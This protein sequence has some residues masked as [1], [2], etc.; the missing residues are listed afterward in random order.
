VSLT[1]PV[2]Q[3]SPVEAG[4]PAAAIIARLVALDHS[5]ATAESITGG[6]IAGRLTAVAGASAVFRGGLIVY[7][8]DLKTRLAG[9][10]ADLIAEAG[11]VSEATARGLAQGAQRAC[12]ADW[13][14][15]VT[16]VA[17]PGPSAGVPAGT[18][19][20]AVAGPGGSAAERLT[21]TGDR[22]AVRSA[23]VDAA[24]AALRSR[25]DTADGVFPGRGADREC[26]VT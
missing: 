19:W 5:L 25:L 26:F 23:V 16:G 7:S 2:E 21:L 22:A 18:V 17:G 14:V 3:G 1:G 6:L 4:D 11:V 24:L 13:G 8:T 10:P 9:V 15:G 12:L 20:L